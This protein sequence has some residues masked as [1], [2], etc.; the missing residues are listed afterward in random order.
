MTA[1]WEEISGLVL[2]V[3][4][5][6]FSIG[7]SALLR[8]ASR[9]GSVMEGMIQVV[10]LPEKRRVY[11]LLMSLEGALFVLSGLVLGCTLIGILPQAPGTLAFVVLF[12][13]GIAFMSARTVL[14]LRPSKLSN[15]QVAAVHRELPNSMPGLA[16]IPLPP[17]GEG[18]DP[19][20]RLFVFAATTPTGESD[21]VH[22]RRARRLPTKGGSPEGPGTAPTPGKGGAAK[23]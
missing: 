3:T 8:R 16:F 15:E 12:V 4:A 2:V 21:P 14:G 13:L 9:G 6:A 19:G 18:R 11:L 1:L 23:P 20:Q 17:G 7:S 5:V 10:F 22:P